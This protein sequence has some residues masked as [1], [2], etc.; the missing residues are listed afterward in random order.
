MKFT[1]PMVNGLELREV[2][3]LPNYQDKIVWTSGDA[4]LERVAATDWTSKVAYSCAAEPIFDRLSLITFWISLNGTRSALASL[5]MARRN[6]RRNLPP[7][8]WK[9]RTGSL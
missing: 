8:L 9:K 2:L 3:A 7:S 6:S 4:A 1:H 5:L